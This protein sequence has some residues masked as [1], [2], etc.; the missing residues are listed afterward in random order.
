MTTINKIAPRTAQHWI[1]LWSVLLLCGAALR[2]WQLG[3]PELRGDEAFSWQYAAN[4]ANPAAIVKTI[5]QEGDPQP[6]LH[7]WLLHYW[8]RIFGQ[9]EF[10][11][12]LPSAFLSL[13][14][15]PA[16][17]R[18]LHAWGVDRAV[19][20]L[21]SVLTAAHP[22]Q[23]WLAQDV[24][25]MYQLAVL[26]SLL[27]LAQVP[28]L[29]TTQ[30]P[31]RTVGYFW[32]AAT[33]AIYTHYYTLFAWLALGLLA[34]VWITQ[35]QRRTAAIKLLI[36]LCAVAAS[37]LPWMMLIVPIWQRGQL[38]DP[39][40][41]TLLDFLRHTLTD[42][43]TGYQ[44]QPSNLT[45]ALWLT[46]SLGGVVYLWQRQ[47]DWAILAVLW[48]GIALFGIYAVTRQR[49]TL[50]TFYLLLAF[51]AAYSL[52]AAGAIALWRTLPA[53]KLANLGLAGLL[54]IYGLSV[55]GPLQHHYATGGGKNNGIRAAL[56]ALQAQSQAHDTFIRNAP[57]PVQVYYLRQ[58][59][60][61]QVLLPASMPT[62]AEIIATALQQM[63]PNTSRFWF[64]PLAWANW[65]AAQLV[66][67]GLNRYP[68]LGC[69]TFGQQ[70]LWQYAAD[71]PTAT[72]QVPLGY[73]LSDTHFQNGIVLRAYHYPTLCSTKPE[74]GVL[75][76]WQTNQPQT[77]D[78]TVFV[79]WGQA[80]Q[81]PLLQ[82]DGVPAAGNLPQAGY[83]PTS[84]WQVGENIFDLH[85]ATA[86]TTPEGWAASLFVGLYDS[87]TGTRLLT[88]QGTDAVQLRAWHPK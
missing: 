73:Q 70:Q 85:R 86:P 84:S 61:P 37:L 51:P 64:I 76:V 15:I 53:G 6:P 26:F 4:N 75:L 49:A 30:H 7:Y 40:Q 41:Q 35:A 36:G 62:T 24:R 20:V 44:A 77:A 43:S 46:A 27:A 71:P 69:Q 66:H 12:R 38:A 29:Q 31:W 54:L 88:K 23:I 8:I 32:L 57:D 19:A 82:A 56:T 16:C 83:R 65:D 42:F 68:F 17:Y 52:L 58:S 14:L 59:T 21:T 80:G 33:L 50:N 22:Y 63:Q 34:L 3:Q 45:A 39:S 18:M 79:H 2:L 67:T 78:Y 28:A 25:N 47:R 74:V 13:L 60:L 11:M 81:P 72:G 1:I 9:T 48:F 55:F 10:A 5:I 87:N